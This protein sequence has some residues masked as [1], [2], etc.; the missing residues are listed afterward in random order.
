M[1]THE[2]KDEMQRRNFYLS[3]ELIERAERIA[4][5]RDWNLS[6]LCR[7]ALEDFL[8]RLEREKIKQELEEG[9]KANHQYYSKMSEE[10]QFADTI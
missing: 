6:Q 2:S 7:I 8:T 3:L 9:Y 4:A 5:E 10:W 1:R